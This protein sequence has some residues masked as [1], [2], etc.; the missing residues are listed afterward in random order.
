MCVRH[1]LYDF[2]ESKRRRADDR[3]I[4]K[5]QDLLEGLCLYFDKALPMI[6]LYRQERPQVGDCHHHSS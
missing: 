5:Y 1:I 2:L 3:Q 4:A 6:L